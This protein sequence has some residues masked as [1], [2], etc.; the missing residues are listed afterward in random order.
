M[1][2]DYRTLYIVYFE[3]LFGVINEPKEIQL[4]AEIL[5]ANDETKE[6][7]LTEQDSKYYCS[8]QNYSMLI[9][10]IY[11]DSYSDEDMYYSSAYETKYK[12]TVLKSNGE[13]QANIVY[14]PGFYEEDLILETFTNGYIEF[15]DETGNLRG[16][17]DYNGN[18]VSILSDY[19]IRDI[20]DDKVIL[21]IDSDYEDENYSIN[22]KVESY[23]IIIDFTGKTLLQTTALD[24]YDNMYLVKNNNRKMVL[25]DQNLNVITKEYD[26]IITNDS[27][28]FSTNYSSYY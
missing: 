13:L 1:N 12:V 2:E 16:W 4:I 3:F 20:K 27:V 25:L 11:D 21:Q 15:E 5:E 23:F 17:Y 19:S 24:I 18:Q 22:P 8:N 6:I 9:E 26:K 14:L 7:V 28:D 10:P